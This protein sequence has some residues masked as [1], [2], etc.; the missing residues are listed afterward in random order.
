[1]ARVVPSKTLSE[2]MVVASFAEV[3]LAKEGHDGPVGVNLLEKVQLPTPH[4]IYGALLAGVDYVLM[5]AGIPAQIPALLD[6]LSRGLACDYRISVA[7]SVPGAV[8]VVHFDPSALLGVPDPQ[9]ARPRSP[10]LLPPNTLP[11]F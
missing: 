3:W 10:A 9:H 7:G 6:D 4:T 2:L 1:M 8:D 11:P 5:G